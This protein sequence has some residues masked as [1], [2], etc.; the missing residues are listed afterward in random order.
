VIA[1]GFAEEGKVH[2]YD[3]ALLAADKNREAIKDINAMKESKQKAISATIPRSEETF[4]KAV[5]AIKAGQFTI[6]Q[7]KEKP[8]TERQK[9]IVADL[10]AAQ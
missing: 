5:L 8:L 1:P 9:K 7:L 3:A 2:P 10:E 6:A 4:D